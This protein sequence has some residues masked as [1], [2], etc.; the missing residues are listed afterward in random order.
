MFNKNPSTSFNVITG[1]EEQD[2]T[3]KKQTNKEKEK[4]IIFLC[5][6]REVSC[7]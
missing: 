5:K 4:H 1:S 2:K 3:T 6:I 7:G